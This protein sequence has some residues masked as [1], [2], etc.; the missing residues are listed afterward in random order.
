MKNALISVWDK[1]G[2]LDLAGEL[3]RLG[4]T[5][6]STGGTAEYLLKNGVTVVPT[7]S[8]TSF[9][10]L[11]G[12]KVKS[13]HPYIHAAILADRDDPNQIGELERLGIE[14]IDVV[15]VNFY[16]FKNA[17]EEKDDLDEIVEFIDIG[18]PAMLRAAAKNF[19]HVVPLCDVSDYG[20]VAKKLKD[21]S[22][23]LEDRLK[24]ACKAF[25]YSAWYDA[26]V[27]SYFSRF[28]EEFFPQLLTLTY[29]KVCELRYGENPHQKAALYKDP[30]S[31]DGIV[32]AQKL[33]GKELSFNN[34]VD[35]DSAFSAVK[36]FDEP[37]CVVVK[38]ANPCAVACAET[39]LQAFEKVWSADPVSIFGGIVAFNR[40]LDGETAQRMVDIFLEVVVAPSYSEE[41]LSI[42]KKKKNL[43]LLR[44]SLEEKVD[45]YDL[46]KLSGGLLFQ[47][48]DEIDYRELRIVSQRKPTEKELQ[49]LLFAWK[50]VKHVKSNA[51]V[52]AKDRST[53]A[54]GMG[55]PNRLWPTEHC[56]RIAGE[57]SKGSVLASDA[58]FPFPD[59]VELAA[60]SGVSA[61]IQPGGSIRD[62]EVIEVADRYGIAMVFTG[63]RHFKH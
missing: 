50:V 24:L 2:I 5:I 16:P 10:Q 34:L 57:N 25:Q 63:T 36:E 47:T 41:A 3:A 38:H 43:R 4:F 26:I 49:D 17:I 6:M 22:L 9:N 52:L 62:D 61:I 37:C 15:V 13:L 39:L 11:L 29:E 19:K 54:V 18:G 56:L 60:K 31:R 40:T 12:G 44:V 21:G 42:L 27:S 20:W 14:P 7:S 59:A 55:Q 53:L 28:A 8:I 35:A 32:N 45:I 33:H 30:L 58:F 51:I 23:S 1:S 48:P 46:R